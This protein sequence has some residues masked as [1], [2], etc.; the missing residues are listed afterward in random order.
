[1]VV[2][3]AAAVYL[4]TKEKDGGGVTPPPGD[5]TP[6][7]GGPPTVKT[8]SLSVEVIA[9]Y[10]NVD[11]SP[12]KSVFTAGETVTLAARP[13]S[14]FRFNGWRGDISNNNDSIT[15]TMNRN[16]HLTTSFLSTVAPEPPQKQWR[17]DLYQSGK[18]SVI[19]SPAY[20]E[21]PDGTNVTIKAQPEA[22]WDFDHFE[23]D[24]GV[25][26][27]YSDT[28]N[29]TMVA[30]RTLRVVFKEADHSPV[31]G[32]FHLQIRTQPSPNYGMQFLTPDDLAY[33]RDFA[34][35]TQI[36]LRAEPSGE[37]FDYWY[38]VGYAENGTTWGA[39]TTR[40]NPATL[41]FDR[42]WVA[43]AYYKTL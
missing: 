6:P 18:G 22:G 34:P 26:N 13:G 37:Y 21:F 23:G 10:G 36:Q 17:I 41:K 3:V 29:W 38:M 42:D 33:Q 8:Y 20:S 39:Y 43:T 31:K 1:M 9:G 2:A 24:T 12:N 40:D 7:S 28:M 35:G 30:N 27:Y 19:F 4:L 11:I 15:L 5:V 16:Y 14:G 32:Y 25:G